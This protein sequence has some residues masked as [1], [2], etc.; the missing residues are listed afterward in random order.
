MRKCIYVYTKNGKT[1]YIYLHFLWHRECIYSYTFDGILYVYMFT[2]FGRDIMCKYIYILYGKEALEQFIFLYWVTIS[3]Y[4]FILLLFLPAPLILLLFDGHP[5]NAFFRLIIS[6]CDRC[7]C[8]YHW[9][10]PSMIL[11]HYVWDVM[12]YRRIFLLLCPQ[13]PECLYR[14]IT[15]SA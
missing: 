10:M 14:C 2:F 3:F 9:S 1:V 6:Q 5:R 13:W 11:P 8:H 15:R 4:C 7:P 12:V